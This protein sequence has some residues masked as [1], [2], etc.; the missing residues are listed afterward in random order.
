M[1]RILAERFLLG[2]DPNDTE[3]LWEIMRQRSFWALGEAP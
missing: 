2:Q 3:T 1:I